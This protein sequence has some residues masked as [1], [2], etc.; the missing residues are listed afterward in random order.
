MVREF[1]P[2]YTE[3]FIRDVVS[4]LSSHDLARKWKVHILHVSELRKNLEAAVRF[5]LRL[6]SYLRG[7]QLHQIPARVERPARPPFQKLQI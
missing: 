3:A 5:M 6:S 2:F 7:K 4:D 1:G